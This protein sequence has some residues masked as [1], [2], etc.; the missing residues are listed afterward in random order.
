VKSSAILFGRHDLTIIGLL[1]LATV[2]L[3]AVN[4]LLFDLGAV[5]YVGVTVVALLLAH[6]LWSCRHRHRDACFRAF[7]HSRWVGLVVLVALILDLGI[8]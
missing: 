8:G 7:M 5:Y 3:L 4:G 1:Q 6:Q 2:A